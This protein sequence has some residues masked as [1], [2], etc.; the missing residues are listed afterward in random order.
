LNTGFIALTRRLNML[1]AASV[2]PTLI[3]LVTAAALTISAFG[4]GTLID[5]PGTVNVVVSAEG[6]G[7]EGTSCLVTTCGCWLPISRNTSS[8]D[9][10]GLS[11]RS[12]TSAR[13]GTKLPC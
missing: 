6:S 5:V 12:S 10:G 3:T 2:A 8:L 1:V 11:S 7:L 13:S 9:M 4:T